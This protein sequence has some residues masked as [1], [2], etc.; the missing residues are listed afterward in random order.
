MKEKLKIKFDEFLKDGR[1]IILILFILQLVLNFFITP[2]RYDDSWFIDQ[3]ENTSII[4]F[5]KSRYYE[6]SSRVIIETVLCLILSLSR[7]VWIVLNSLMITLI[8]YSISKLFVKEN[9]QEMNIMIALLVLIYP[10]DRMHE[11]GWGATTING[12]W[13]LALGLFSMIPIRKIFDGEKIKG[14][15]YPL[16]S[17]ALIYAG[18]QE[19]SCMILLA[20]YVLFTILLV[21]RD[22]NKIHP[23]M[24][25]QTVLIVL[26]L[27]FVLTCPGNYIRTN[28]EIAMNYPDFETLTL[29]DKVSMGVT[30]TI[31]L[32]LVNSNIIFLVFSI[33]IA[34]YICTCYKSTLYKIVSIIPFVAI[35]VLGIFKDIFVR[36]FPH[37]QLLIDIMNVQKPMIDASNYRNI[38]NSLPIILSFVI[39][40]SFVLSII[41]IFKKLKNNTA[42]VI[43][44]VGLVSRVVMG[45]SPT[46]FA[47]T[48][49]T[50]IFLEFGMLIITFLIWQEF[51]KLTSD[52]TERKVQI[53]LYNII[54]IAAIVQYINTLLF[55][56]ATQAI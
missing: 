42:I 32:M 9:K 31:S 33:I 50:F 22:K 2:D 24:I 17:L 28:T 48:N 13:P 55:I 52:K 41:L 54:G 20:V 37:L 4:D 30:T 43:F 27:I 39:I 3:L 44:G 14:Y 10:L 46:I 56:L 47:S 51:I 26:S 34:L 36:I 40:F 5:V 53:R 21:L 1:S 19:Q 38:I 11:A 6:W 49:R 29:L 25:V 18:N 8:G 15:M 23:F 45:L 35:L 16:Y 12:L 7:Y